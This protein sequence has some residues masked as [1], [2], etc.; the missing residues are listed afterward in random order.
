MA[1]LAPLIREAAALLLCGARNPGPSFGETALCV[2]RAGGWDLAQISDA[3]ATE[4]D[5]L[6]SS[7]GVRPQQTGWRRLVLGGV[8]PNASLTTLR[9][10]LAENLLARVDEVGDPDLDGPERFDGVDAPRSDAP[11]DSAASPDAGSSPA[12]SR[13][14]QATTPY[15]L[16]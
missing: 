9:D 11:V 16:K 12:T 4:I 6:A 8:D 5:R 3:D 10:H 7:L 15:H 14:R 1:R 13:A 2:A